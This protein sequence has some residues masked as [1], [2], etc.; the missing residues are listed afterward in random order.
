M[1][2]E[3]IKTFKE[4]E[5]VTITDTVSQN[6]DIDVDDVNWLIAQYKRYYTDFVDFLILRL[7]Q[8]ELKKHRTTTWE[9]YNPTKP[10][11]K[12]IK[13]N[14]TKHV[15]IGIMHYNLIRF[16]QRQL[17]KLQ[18][19][20]CTINSQGMNKKRSSILKMKN[21]VVAIMT[22]Y[23]AVEDA[24]DAMVPIVGHK[25]IPEVEQ[26]IINAEKLKE[27][28]MQFLKGEKNNDDT[29]SKEERENND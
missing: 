17:E 4:G 6:S 16:L 9:N 7:N 22:T 1:N 28:L 15:D 25:F 20:Y 8:S 5:E 14:Y 10:I 23:M 26:G 12:L 2:N 3:Y 21:I 19:E 27:N 13:A 29:N 24:V 11:F 18:A